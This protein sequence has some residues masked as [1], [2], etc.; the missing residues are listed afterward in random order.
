[1]NRL[2]LLR[3]D[4]Y[5]VKEMKT[6]WKSSASVF[7]GRNYRNNDLT[8]ILPYMC[9][10]LCCRVI[11]V[12]TAMKKWKTDLRSSIFTI[13]QTLSASNRA[14]PTANDRDDQL[15]ISIWYWYV[16]CSSILSFIHAIRFANNFFCRSLKI[17]AIDLDM[18]YH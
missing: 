2:Y 15:K 9:I 7:L 5:C 13:F 8:C 6:Q 4:R 12:D 16:L 10:I 1:M 14:N 3:N 17:R 18:R 11:H